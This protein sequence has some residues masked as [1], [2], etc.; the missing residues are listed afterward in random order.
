[1][2]PPKEISGARIMVEATIPFVESTLAYID[3][4][5]GPTV[6]YE[7]KREETTH[8]YDPHRVPI[9]DARAERDL[10]LERNG[11]TLI[12][13]HSAVTDFR[14]PAQIKDVYYREVER[15]VMS[16]TGAAKVLVFGDVLRSDDPVKAPLVPP[17]GGIGARDDIV[18]ADS[19]RG[20][21][22]VPAMQVHET[23]NNPHID[24]NEKTVRRLAAG[25]LGPEA[26]RYAKKRVALIN[27]WRGIK[28][29]ERKPLA[30][31]DA[32]TVSDQHLVLGLIGTRPEDPGDFLEGFNVAYSPAHRWYYYPRM[33]PD[34]LLV[35]KLCDSDRG[36]PQLTAH[37]AFDDPTSAAGAPPRQSLEIR[38]I[39][40]FA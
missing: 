8:H 20:D 24:F 25:M 9:H 6:L 37:T 10:S 11:F 18:F 16:M 15:L 39:S 5:F 14:D 33:R 27:L 19:A 7:Y 2:A 17:E 28:T 12:E 21:R 22:Q 36:L 34:E 23:A 30:V 40:F 32:R 1:M 13:H 26:D 31:C 38:T 3:P 29:V 35:F 4:S